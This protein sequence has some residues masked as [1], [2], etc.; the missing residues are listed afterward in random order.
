MNTKTLIALAGLLCLAGWAPAALAQDYR[1]R[2][3]DA[4]RQACLLKN[5]IY[6]WDVVNERTLTVRDS[7]NRRYTVHLSGGC[8]GL[9]NANISIGLRSWGSTLGCLGQGDQISFR[10]F[11]LNRRLSCNVTGV[12][13]Y[14]APRPRDDD[15]DRS[16]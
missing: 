1:D 4:P 5:R 2:D 16:Y 13:P 3:R 6:G 9:D 8:I 15:R 10:S 14:V 11:G 7:S 12:E